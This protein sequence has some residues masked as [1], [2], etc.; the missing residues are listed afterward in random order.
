MEPTASGSRP[1]LRPK[2]LPGEGVR[3][4][5]PELTR[6]LLAKYGDLTKKSL[7]QTRV[8]QTA[9]IVADVAASRLVQ[10]AASTKRE[11]DSV[12][13]A[14]MEARMTQLMRRVEQLESALRARDEQPA[15]ISPHV[16]DSHRDERRRGDG[17]RGVDP[18]PSLLQQP[19]SSVSFAEVDPSQDPTNLH[20]LILPMGADGPSEALLPPKGGAAEDSESGSAGL[21]GPEREIG[22]AGLVALLPAADG[23]CSI[24]L[25]REYHEPVRHA[26]TP[27]PPPPCACSHVDAT[28]PPPIVPSQVV[29]LT[30]AP[31]PPG[32]P[33]TIRSD[34][35]RAFA[36]PAA[37]TTSGHTRLCVTRLDS[38]SFEL[39]AWP[40]PSSGLGVAY[41]VLEAGV[42]TLAAGATL[43][44][45]TFLIP[46]TCA[47]G[48]SS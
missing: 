36:P 12:P 2:A 5:D 14:E 25:E 27:R 35:D 45:G 29:I 30:L 15:H 10:P 46:L 22:E 44:A 24:R 38:A 18:L 42:H 20:P 13:R 31:A 34:A 33:S 19:E 47:A 4:A 8:S 17:A 11:G 7:V 21:R 37:A 23:I 32:S 16:R 3:Y 6:K 43:I 9:R 28:P 39:R 41:I 1:F 40:P 48:V 26:S